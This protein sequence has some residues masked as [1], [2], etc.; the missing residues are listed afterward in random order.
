MTEEKGGDDKKK[1]GMTE[2]KGGNDRRKRRG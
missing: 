2:E 1:A